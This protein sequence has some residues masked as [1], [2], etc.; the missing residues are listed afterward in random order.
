MVAPKKK[1][2]VDR[3]DPRPAIEERYQGRE[4]YL[5]RFRAA[6]ERRVETGF[7]RKEDVAGMTSQG[8]IH[9]R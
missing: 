5:R 7:L 6:A 1:E 4:D 8:D 9:D 3:Q 2:R